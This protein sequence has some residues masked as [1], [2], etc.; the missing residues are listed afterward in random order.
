MSENT[1]EI[2]TSDAVGGQVDPPVMRQMFSTD[3]QYRKYLRCK[4]FFEKLIQ[5]AKSDHFFMVDGE[6]YKN[7]Y[8]DG[9]KMG[10]KDGSINL[11]FVG[12][13]HSYNRATGK[14]DVTWIDV[15]IKE[16]LERIKPLKLVKL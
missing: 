16:L 2:D 13:T 12:C 5:L 15:T 10:F 8:I 7:P 3:G 6:V 14:Y 1:T 11:V 4:I 9:V